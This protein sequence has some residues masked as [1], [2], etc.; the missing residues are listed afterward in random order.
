MMM[1]MVVRLHVMAQRHACEMVGWLQAVIIVRQTTVVVEVCRRA[2]GTAAAVVNAVDA[3][4]EEISA[5]CRPLVVIIVV[6]RW[7]E[8]IGVHGELAYR[9]REIE[10]C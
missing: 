10:N 4:L 6:V 5:R 3:V 2:G 7:V 1:M 9:S 8:M